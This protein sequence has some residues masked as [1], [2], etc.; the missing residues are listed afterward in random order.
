ME[1]LKNIGK[2]WLELQEK[3]EELNELMK[4]F[5]GNQVNH[6]GKVGYI[7]HIDPANEMA[8]VVFVEGGTELIYLSTFY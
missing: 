4:S 3:E 2:L 8:S 6:R 5:E 7:H 1:G